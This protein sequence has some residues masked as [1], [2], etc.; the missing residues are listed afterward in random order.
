MQMQLYGISAVTVDFDVWCLQSNKLSRS[1]NTG[2]SQ[3]S[4]KSP[5]LFSLDLFDNQISILTLTHLHS[6]HHG[7][8]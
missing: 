3:L 5:F 2:V 8:Q 6:L 4:L 1:L 7:C